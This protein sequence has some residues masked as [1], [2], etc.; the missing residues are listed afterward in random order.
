MRQRLSTGLAARSDS[1]LFGTATT[2]ASFLLNLSENKD[3]KS[4]IVLNEIDES[5]SKIGIPS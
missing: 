3:T 5:I 2:Y 4:C 1:S